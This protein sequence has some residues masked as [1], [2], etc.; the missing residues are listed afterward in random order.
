MIDVA[1][2]MLGWGSTVWWHWFA[3]F[4]R[5]AAITSLLPAFGEQSLPTRVKLGAAV[6]FAIVSAPAIGNLSGGFEN[7]QGALGSILTEIANGLVLGIGVRMFV[8]TLQTAGAIAAQATSLSQLFAGA[9]VEPMP[10]IGHVLLIGGL[11]LAMTFGLHVRAAQ[12]IVGS[13]EVFPPGQ[14][15][16]ADILSQWGVARISKAFALSFQ[17]AAPFVI[18]SVLYNLTL[19]VI[20]RA[21]P[22]LMV[23]FVGA[24]VITAGGLVL[25]LVASPLMLSTWLDALHLFL[26]GADWSGP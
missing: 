13:Y 25:L 12:F 6:A 10:A 15:P 3:V 14:L 23:A 5:A 11:A 17:L 9:G 2:E 8:I 7:L 19:G 22:Q 4:L 21:M 1:S 20:N 24:P 16:G 26:S 18:A